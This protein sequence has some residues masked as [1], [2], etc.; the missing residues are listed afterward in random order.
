MKYYQVHHWALG[1][2]WGR[3]NVPGGAIKG[4]KEDALVIGKYG[5][6]VTLPCY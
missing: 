6:T 2:G 3:K 1:N 5:K 4:N